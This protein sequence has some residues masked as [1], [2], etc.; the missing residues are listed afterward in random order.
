MQTWLISTALGLQI[1]RDGW[2][3]QREA[4]RCYLALVCP[5]GWGVRAEAF[6]WPP[7]PNC[8]HPWGNTRVKCCCG[9]PGGGDGGWGQESASALPKVEEGGRTRLPHQGGHE[10]Q[11][12]V[13]GKAGVGKRSPHGEAVFSAGENGGPLS[14]FFFLYCYII[15]SVILICLSVIY[16]KWLFIWFNFSHIKMCSCYTL[17]ATFHIYNLSTSQNRFPRGKFYCSK[18]APL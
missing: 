3:D 8:L 4:Q 10:A 14:L 9:W 13:R 5:H 16:C 11:E 17:S 15:L 12:R 2:G 1:S 6:H 18:L 7:C